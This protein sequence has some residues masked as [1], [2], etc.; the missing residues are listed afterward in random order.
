M[1]RNTVRIGGV[2]V[3]AAFALG[4][5][6]TAAQAST[7]VPAPRATVAATQDE[8]QAIRQAAGALLNSGI[9]YSAADRAELEAIANGESAAAGKWDKA[10]E[11]L[12]KVPGFAKA[13]G[14][15]YADFKKWYGDLPWYVKAPLTAAGVGSDLYSIWELFH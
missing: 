9:E 4:F 12:K 13:V 11:L 2:A 1:N 3:L 10:L 6:G 14:G 15:K 5:G 8:D 7:A